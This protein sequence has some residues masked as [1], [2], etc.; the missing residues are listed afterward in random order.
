MRSELLDGL[1][2]MLSSA[3]EEIPGIEN[4]SDKELEEIYRKVIENTHAELVSDTIRTLK[5]N[6]RKMLKERR[7]I[8][9]GFE[10]RNYSRWKNSI[11]HFEMLIVVASELGEANARELHQWSKDEESHVFSAITQLHAKAILVSN[12][13][14]CLLLGGF[15]DGAL[16]RW[17]TLH[18]LNVIA[19][20]IE[21]HGDIIAK[22]YLASFYFN[23][24]RA[25]NQLNE[26]SDRANLERFTQEELRDFDQVCDEVSKEI[27]RNI[28]S[29]FDWANLEK[30]KRKL[31]LFDLEKDVGMDHWRPRYRWASQHNH[32]GHRPY[33][34]MLGLKESEQE[35]ALIGKSNS[36]FVDPL[37]MASMSLAHI[38]STHLL[39]KPNLD[40]VV[41]SEIIVQLGNELGTIAINEETATL[42]N[43]QNPGFM[44]RFI[45]FLKGM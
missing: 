39:I 44:M 34:K 41:M 21:K 36:G 6:A 27:G 25:A 40:R 14:L 38:T 19:A 5:K 10:R 31:T 35:V 23:A 22:N 32:G 43:H 45:R 4:L 1:E 28:K 9:N 30:S 3:V 15:P 12:E 42:E 26:Y 2:D 8:D 18:E 13:V 16:A 11:D 29:E 17:R 20:Y 37:Q 33:D 7:R 24:R